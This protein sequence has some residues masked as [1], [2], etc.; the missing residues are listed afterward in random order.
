[1]YT[2]AFMVIEYTRGYTQSK[3]K[4]DKVTRIY[5]YL[6]ILLGIT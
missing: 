5:M 1:M 2:F 6:I 3:R 4:R